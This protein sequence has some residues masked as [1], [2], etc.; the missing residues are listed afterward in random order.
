MDPD[1]KLMLDFAKG[2][3][4]AFER[5]MN[6]YKEL[7]MN[8]AYRFLQDRSKA[9]DIAQEVFIKVYNSAGSYKP[10]AKL[11]TWIYKITANLC[12]NELRSQKH[13]KA[14]SVEAIGETHD[15]IQVNPIENLEKS[16]LKQL[17]REAVD[18]LP[19]RQ[20]IVVILQKYEDLSYQE[21]SEII[22]CSVSAVDSLLQR[23]KQKLKHKLTLIFKNKT[24]GF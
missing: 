24:E 15:S 23:A 7:V 21:I 10:K 16:K 22:G 5:I 3:I 1:T 18:S 12:L 14:I 19:D 4:S 8:I 13:F 2:D 11:S 20:R 17:V 6:R 9:E